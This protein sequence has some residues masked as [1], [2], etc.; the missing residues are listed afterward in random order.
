M[1][2]ETLLE[3]P[4][5]SPVYLRSGCMWRG[6]AAGQP[7][8][9]LFQDETQLGSPGSGRSRR[10][11]DAPHLPYEPAEA[12][13]VSCSRVPTCGVNL[14]RCLR[15]IGPPLPPEGRSWELKTSG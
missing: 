5:P 14:G 12:S 2:E 11:S 9:I 4:S 10:L 6:G 3:T 7:P 15:R 13:C 8:N 1:S